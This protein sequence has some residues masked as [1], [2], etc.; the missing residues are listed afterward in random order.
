VLLA[1]PLIGLGLAL[2]VSSGPALDTLTLGEEVAQTLGI[3][4]PAVRARVVLGIALVTGAGVAV[5]GSIGF[6]GLVVPHL[7]R[8]FVGHRPG[9]AIVPAALAGAA[10]LLAADIAIRLVP[11]GIDLRL[12]VLTGLIGAPFF[13]WLILKGR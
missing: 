3:A 6:V 13:L 4:L 11:A 1:V 8:P 5:A 12:G 9:A 10:L 7:V 2:L